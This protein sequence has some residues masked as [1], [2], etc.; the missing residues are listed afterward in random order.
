MAGDVA[1]KIF[2]SKTGVDGGAYVCPN[3][4]K[5]VPTTP[6]RLVPN[7]STPVSD[8]AESGRLT[9]RFDDPRYYTGDAV[10]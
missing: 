10:T 5:I 2:P 6:Q 4:L 8:T 7:I 9:N 1:R 3:G